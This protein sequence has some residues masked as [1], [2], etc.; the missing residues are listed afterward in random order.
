[1]QRQTSGRPVP[2]TRRRALVAVGLVL[3]LLAACSG[4]GD[5]DPPSTAAV[6]AP[7]AATAA[8]TR[9][10][11]TDGVVKPLLEGIVVTNEVPSRS[12][13]L[14]LV[15]GLALNVAWSAVQPDQDGEIVAGNPLDQAIAQIRRTNAECG[16]SLGIRARVLAGI[17]APDWA[18]SIAGEP[19]EVA[20]A[21]DGVTGT[22]GRF[23][24]APFGAA[25]ADLQRRLAEAYDGVPEI[26]EV[27]ISRCTT[28]YAEPTLRGAYDAQTRTNL[29]AAGYTTE[30]DRRCQSEQVDAHG[31]W[32]TT[33]SGLA[34][35]PYQRVEPGGALKGDV[36]VSEE[37]M[38]YCRSVLAERCVLQNNSIR[39]PLQEGAY[40][41]LY[42]ALA[43]VGPP[44]SFQTAA[45]KRVQ[46]LGKTLEFA[47][48]RGASAVEVTPSMLD[49]VEALSISAPKLRANAARG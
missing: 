6:C 22:T 12:D 1:M 5:P 4:G 42:D 24:E 2:A 30:A 37:L 11:S 41:A 48:D 10:S 16:L 18:K 46:D 47:V 20:I 32:R 3:C 29:L 23:W 26:R 38:R 21:Q 35:N 33:R 7:G 19:V 40:P 43:R 44:I 28:V 15:G 25:Y 49:E 27:V 39:W 8:E 36:S 31:V 9:A 13:Q 45:P 14:R 34:F 17:K